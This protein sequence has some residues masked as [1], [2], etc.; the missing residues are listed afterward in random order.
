MLDL[1][2]MFILFSLF[3]LLM[4][5]EGWLEAHGT[6]YDIQA[7]CTQAGPAHAAGCGGGMDRWQHSSHFLLHVLPVASIA[8]WLEKV[9]VQW[10][11]HRHRESG[12]KEK[13]HH[14]RLPWSYVY[15]SSHWISKSVNG[16]RPC[17]HHWGVRLSMVQVFNSWVVFELTQKDRQTERQTNKQMKFTLRSL[18]SLH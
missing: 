5:T 3:G 2:H 9:G 7:C 17:C 8:L 18:E 16:L 14:D 1:T 4:V 10:L 13:W 12:N 15:H 11:Q 6:S